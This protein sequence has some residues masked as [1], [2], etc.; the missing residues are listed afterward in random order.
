MRYP[1]TMTST[2]TPAAIKTKHYRSGLAVWKL[3]E[4][5]ERGG[6]YYAARPHWAV[7]PSDW[8][9]EQVAKSGAIYLSEASALMALGEFAGLLRMTRDNPYP[10]ETANQRISRLT[11]WA[12][13][14]WSL[15]DLK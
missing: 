6:C 2:D 8:T 11:K 13:G 3:P 12:K 4:R 7:A 14:Y 5:P 10:N 15:S 9:P 1:L